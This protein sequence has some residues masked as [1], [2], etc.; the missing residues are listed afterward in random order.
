MKR[1][2]KEREKS[3]L[4]EVTPQCTRIQMRA[5]PREKRLKKYERQNKNKKKL[6]KKI[7]LCLNRFLVG[8]RV[9]E[10]RHVRHHGFFVRIWKLYKFC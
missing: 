7:E 9:V 10:T 2:R 1:V 3:E 8:E 5:R 6:K 4:K